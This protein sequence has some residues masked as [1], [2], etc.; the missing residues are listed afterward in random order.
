MRVSSHAASSRAASELCI[1]APSAVV[2]GTLRALEM[3]MH[4]VLV[5]LMHNVVLLHVGNFNDSSL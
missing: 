4:S 3:A 1:R 2:D 5:P